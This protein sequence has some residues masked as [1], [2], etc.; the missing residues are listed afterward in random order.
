MMAAMS[1]GTALGLGM[2]CK[3]R[4]LDL[5]ALAGR[6]V[7]L[8]MIVAP[9]RQKG[10]DLLADE[11]RPKIEM[12]VV[13]ALAARGVRTVRLPG[14]TGLPE[15]TP[16]AR[17]WND[18]A[19]LLAQVGER[20]LEHGMLLIFVVEG[21]TYAP[22]VEQHEGFTVKRGATHALAFVKVLD[23]GGRVLGRDCF[24]PPPA[25]GEALPDGQRTPA[26]VDAY[27]RD[28]AAAV[29]DHVTAAE[30]R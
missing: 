8:V 3:H 20:G 13:D 30:G 25:V 14:Y 15:R 24:S 29:I 18:E 1:A 27:A 21:A 2:E 10:A 22:V 4:Q 11:L 23:R 6:E 7:G 9:A 17:V 19:T 5:A 26:P 12:E 16:Q 28:L